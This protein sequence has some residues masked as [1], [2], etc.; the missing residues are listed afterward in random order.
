MAT[1]G[2]V[3][4]LLLAFFV[5]LYAISQVDQRKF[6]LFV[7]GLEAPFGN[8]TSSAGLLASSQAL[9]GQDKGPLPADP[10][11]RNVDDGLGLIEE[12]TVNRD[13]DPEEQ[14]VPPPTLVEL[15]DPE[16]L[17]T[18]QDL[19]NLKN[20]LQQDL[21]DAGLS[22]FVD[23]KIDHR[24]LVIAIATDEV[25]FASG[26]TEI[27]DEGQQILGVIGPKLTEFSN[28]VLVEGHTDD[29]PLDREGY[30]NWNLSTDRAVAV[31]HLL[32]QAFGIDQRRLA[33]TGYGEFQPLVDEPTELARAQ[34]RRVELVIVAGKE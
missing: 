24:G 4:T 3:V 31:L 6:Q 13:E 15:P 16:V 23:F 25:A 34:N 8:Q 20:A 17:V 32:N 5:L 11:L 19:I 7:S 28:A 33:A 10:N 26:A 29:V 12:G 27:S 30:D 14:E 18:A 22:E 1:Y 2:D 21:E 9:D